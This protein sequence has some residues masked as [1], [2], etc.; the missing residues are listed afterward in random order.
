M[1]NYT[2]GQDRLGPNKAPASEAFK[3]VED[4]NLTKADL[5]ARETFQNAMDEFELLGNQN[6]NF[7][8]RLHEFSGTQ[9]KSFTI[10]L[11]FKEIERI[12]DLFQSSDHNNWFG[13]G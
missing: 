10:L 5:L 2:W 12:K 1:T 7:V 3:N 8:M 11:D 9:K 4:T 13:E 6:N